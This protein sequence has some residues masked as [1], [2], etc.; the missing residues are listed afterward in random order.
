[1]EESN[2]MAGREACHIC[3]WVFSDLRRNE[4]VQARRQLE[5]V[6]HDMHDLV[7]GRMRSSRRF[8]YGGR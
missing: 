5:K 3:F 1:M 7:Y 6:N 8:K 2:L 4:V